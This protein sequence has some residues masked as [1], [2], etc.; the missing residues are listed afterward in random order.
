MTAITST[1]DCCSEHTGSDKEPKNRTTF[2]KILTNVTSVKRGIN[3]TIYIYMTKDDR[4][5]ILALYI[6]TKKIT[7]SITESSLT[8]KV[9]N[10]RKVP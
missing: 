10:D 6:R 2:I 5:K 7:T 4:P 3:R 9:P 1:G 8:R